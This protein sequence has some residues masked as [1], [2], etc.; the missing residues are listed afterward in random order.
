[1]KERINSK[2]WGE[3]GISPLRPGRE[4]EK[5]GRARVNPCGNGCAGLE[6][7]LSKVIMSF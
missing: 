1:M 6:L 7:W 3:G 5:A 4:H 2:N